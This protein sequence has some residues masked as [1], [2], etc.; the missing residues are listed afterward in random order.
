MRITAI[1]LL[2]ALAFYLFACGHFYLV[3][4]PVSVVI[5][6]TSKTEVDDLFLSGIVMVIV[7]SIV[8]MLKRIFGSL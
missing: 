7:L 3:V 5:Y 8:A 1:V 6:L 2:V 4:L